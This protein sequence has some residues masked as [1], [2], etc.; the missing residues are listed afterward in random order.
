MLRNVI[1]LI[2][3]GAVVFFLTF[4][5]WTWRG[6]GWRDFSHWWDGEGLPIF[7]VFFFAIIIL[8]ANGCLRG[9]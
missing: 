1:S 5:V 8:L 7:I 3:I 9:G 2:A 4:T 6:K